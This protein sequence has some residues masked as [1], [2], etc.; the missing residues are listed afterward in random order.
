MTVL[1]KLNY[2]QIRI[3]SCS[4]KSKKNPIFARPNQQNM[5]RK[6]SEPKPQPVA[7]KVTPDSYDMLWKELIDKLIYDFVEFFMPDLFPKIDF[8]VAPAFLEQELPNIF[9]NR[10]RKGVKYCDKLVKCKLLDGTAQWIFIHIE[11]Q[12]DDRPEF[13]KRMFMYF[14]RIFDKHGIK[15]NEIE[16]IGVY[17]GEGKPPK[18]EFV[19][20]CGKTSVKFKFRLYNIFEASEEE[21]RQ[22][23]NPFAYAVLAAR[24]ALQYKNQVKQL[25]VLKRELF[26]MLIK[27]NYSQEK[28]AIILN[29]VIIAITLP[30]EEEK[31]FKDEV[32]ETFTQNENIMNQ[33]E[34][35]RS[36]F[37]TPVVTAVYSKALED[38]KKQ[39]EQV[40]L[41][42]ECEKEQVILA[43]ERE[44]E[45]VILAKEREKEQVINQKDQVINQKDQVINQKEQEK[46]KIIIHSVI[47]LYEKN[48]PIN[49]IAECLGISATEV[50]TI[51]EE[52]K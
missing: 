32:I 49:E 30:E 48:F 21:L 7:I 3:K 47:K 11:I 44:K 27:A 50:K 12:R 29:F 37:W 15:E 18:N 10:K 31:L 5:P 51:L 26:D 34:E 13:E 40:L 45:Q 16:S 52:K 25:A 38:Y 24:Y 22:S 36:R 41:A 1:L 6:K 8:R 19:Y 2:Y 20:E 17:I 4:C 46:Q 35:L 28:V 14:Y 33:I 42:K 9:S 43:K 39:T 23:N